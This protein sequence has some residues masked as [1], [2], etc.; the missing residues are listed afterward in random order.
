MSPPPRSSYIPNGFLSYVTGV[1]LAQFNKFNGGFRYVQGGPFQGPDDVLVDTYYADQ[2]KYHVGE[3]VTEANRPW[4]LTGIYEPGMLARQ[5]VP[6]ATLQ[7]L[8]GNR[9]NVSTIY[10]K[11]DDPARIGEVIANIWKASCRITKCIP[12][13]STPNFFRSTVFPCCENSPWW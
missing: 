8:T 12:C 13:R 6:L 9:G 3:T 2:H 1:D 4:K 7:D 11:L 5:V 10:V